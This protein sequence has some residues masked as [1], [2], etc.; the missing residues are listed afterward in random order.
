MGYFME[1]KNKFIN[2][3]EF[4]KY[5]E[6]MTKTAYPNMFPGLLEAIDYVKDFP[7]VDVAEVVHGRWLKLSP[8]NHNTQSCICLNCDSISYQKKAGVY[9]GEIPKYCPNCGAKMDE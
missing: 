6:S 3:N 9:I 4:A 8:W 2:A 5:L 1:T 7:S